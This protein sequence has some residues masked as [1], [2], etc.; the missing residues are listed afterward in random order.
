M[1]LKVINHPYEFDMK[2]IC[3]A[4][5][6]Y[7]KIKSD[8]EEDISVITKIDGGTLSVS[9]QV[10]DKKLNKTHTLK[11]NEDAALAMS[12]LL[13]DTLSEI[14]GFRSAW[15]VLYGVRPAKLMHR[16]SQEYGEEGARRYFTEKF[17]VSPEKADL[18]AT[19]AEHENR[20]ISLSRED[21]FSLY[22]SIPFC[23]TRCAY[24]SFVSHS[25]ERTKRLVEP[26]VD[27]LCTELER[28]GKIARDLNLRLETIY[29]GGGTPTTLS[30]PQL[31]KIFTAV[32]DNFDLS[33]LRE[34]TVEAGRP[35]TVDRDKLL[36]LRD[37][38]ITR[39][40]INPQ[41]F[42]D[43]VLEAI[44]RKHTCAQTLEAFALAR[45]CG[46]D[47][48]NM[49]LIA[50]L[51]TDTLKSFEN[52]VDTAVKLG[53]DS[54]TV[55]TLALKT[56]AYLVTRET[57][58]DMTDRIT[59]SKMVDYSRQ[60]LTKHDY[61]PYYMYKQSKSVANLENVGWCR[62]GKPCLYN[63][64]MMDE[65]HSVFAA[66]AGAVTRLK[67]SKSGKIQR[68]YNYKYPY[69][70]IDNFD[71]IISRKEGIYDFYSEYK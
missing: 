27:L 29:F 51:P 26:Y 67:D 34:Y 33:N 41:T 60:T 39:I 68:I 4:F 9:V 48:I 54:V 28:I 47:N 37:F 25:V 6:P 13:Y 59:A 7:E 1:I 3:T 42:N 23:P 66:G 44:G 56:A 69:E 31:K 61:I 22:V 52:S 11:D 36:T 24:C 63:V 19:V 32:R 5:F 18:T 53:A 8:G 35:D 14:L 45:D 62:D 15:G 21:S 16:F 43:S 30:A 58:F 55:H 71:N 17:L 57:A 2:N 50:G 65:T 20:I 12:V 10:F 64:F 38:D 49:D 70:Y 40:S 46:F